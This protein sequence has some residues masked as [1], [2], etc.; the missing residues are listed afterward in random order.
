[1]KRTTWTWLALAALPLAGFA[2]VSQAQEVCSRDVMCVDAVEHGN[3]VDL[4][5]VN[6]QSAEIT[7]TL[8][9][10]TRN[11]RAMRSLPYTETYPGNARTK[12]LTLVRDG[13]PSDYQ[14]NF[15]WTWGT[16]HAHWDPH[17]VYSLPF[18]GDFRVDQGFN[19]KFSHFGEQAYA[20]DFNMPIGT[21][22][23]AARSGVVVGTEDRYTKGAPELRYENRA[24][25]VMIKHAD[26]T[27]GEYAHLMHG[28][29]RVKVGQ[30]VAR[31]QLI[32]YSG[33][34]GYTTGPHLHFFVYKALDGAERESFPVRF[35][36]QGAPTFLA[37]GDTYNGEEQVAVG[38]P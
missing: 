35:M 36:V 26:G 11:M 2:G 37:Q 6:R 14:F 4:Y 22:L 24:N 5:V 20:I 25:Y 31:G 34:V 13:A 19:G 28:G 15:K 12:A 1:M 29:V 32:G 18:H 23:Y 33:N 7:V 38:K 27:I 3:A 17:V 21:P 10:T 30:H 8:D 9:A 16:I